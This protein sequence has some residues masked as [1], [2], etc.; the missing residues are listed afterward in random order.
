MLAKTKETRN[1]EKSGTSK[2]FIFHLNFFKINLTLCDMNIASSV[3][4]C[5]IYG[6]TI[7]KLNTLFDIKKYV[8]NLT[9][10]KYSD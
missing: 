2:R 1:P 10:S 4:Q 9:Q 3:V 6:R 5:L 8:Q 7:L